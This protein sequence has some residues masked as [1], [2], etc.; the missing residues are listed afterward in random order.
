MFKSLTDKKETTIDQMDAGTRSKL[1][2][3]A[4]VGSPTDNP[5][6]MNRILTVFLPFYL[7]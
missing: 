6:A 3:V 5:Q 4:V 2:A 1:L 7:S